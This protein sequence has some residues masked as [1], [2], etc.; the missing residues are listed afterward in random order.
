MII[1]LEPSNILE[2]VYILEVT[3][4]TLEDRRTSDVDLELKVKWRRPDGHTVIT[5][6]AVPRLLIPGSEPRVLA[7]KLLYLN[8]YNSVLMTNPVH[9]HRSIPILH[10]YKL[11][12]A[13]LHPGKPNNARSH[14]PCFHGA[15]RNLPF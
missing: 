13:H 2:I 7:G 11:A 6:L 10:G 5:P 15:Q 3:K 12:R 1:E 9:F 14:V 4:R 8:V